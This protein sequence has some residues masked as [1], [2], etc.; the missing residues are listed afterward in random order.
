M[1]L[2]H[3]SAIIVLQDL[4]LVISNYFPD[5]APC[6]RFPSDFSGGPIMFYKPLKKLKM[7]GFVSWFR[8]I[9]PNDHSKCRN[10]DQKRK[11][12]GLRFWP[13]KEQSK[14]KIKEQT[15]CFQIH[16]HEKHGLILAVNSKTKYF[17]DTLESYNYLRT[18]YRSDNR[19]GGDRGIASL[20]VP[21]RLKSRIREELAM[22]Y[23]KVIQIWQQ[24][25]C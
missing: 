4:R 12:L 8:R 25:K 20:N 23:H 13:L 18:F 11:Q 9:E 21:N 3:F 17:G 6:M 24:V 5:G 14:V 10:H 22:V 16:G 2:T 1:Y 15:F 19:Q 7:E